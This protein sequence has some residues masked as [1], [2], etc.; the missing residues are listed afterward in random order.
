[1]L[2]VTT[3]SDGDARDGG[4]EG[5][6]PKHVNSSALGTEERA[7]AGVKSVARRP[8]A[9]PSIFALLS[10]HTTEAIDTDGTEQRQKERAGNLTFTL[11]VDAGTSLRRWGRLPE[12]TSIARSSPRCIAD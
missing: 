9:V 3:R 7:I 6:P 10:Q 12:L 1:M 4:G 11:R 2:S 5:D 8:R